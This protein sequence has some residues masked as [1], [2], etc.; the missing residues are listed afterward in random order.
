MINVKSLNLRIALQFA[1]ILLPLVALLGYVTH[2][3]SRRAAD[4]SRA[5]AVHATVI[6]ARDQFALF[7]NGAAD[8]VDTGH[9]SA[10]A[11]KALSDASMD[12]D[13]L[14]AMQTDQASAQA[15]LSGW[16]RS[17]DDVLR[18][19]ASVSALTPLRVP[20][21]R[22]RERIEQLTRIHQAKLDQAIAGSIKEADHSRTLV[23][24]LSVFL[25]LVTITF[26][27]QMMR[28]L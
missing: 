23:V 25:L 19:D 17:I 28:G 7:L 22:A 11:R 21:N 2:A 15:E 12:I 18:S 6:E 8:S 1:V 9:L 4:M 10:R 3:E 24:I 26:I 16:L 14:M 13:K 5:V 27:V 20:M